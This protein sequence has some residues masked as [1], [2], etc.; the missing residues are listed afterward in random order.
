MTYTAAAANSTSITYSLVSSPA[1]AGNT[2]DASTGAV[3]YVAGFFGTATITASA[4]GCN[5]PKTA[6]HVATIDPLPSAAGTITGTSPV[7]ARATGVSYS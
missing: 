3:T 1:N 2:I 4:A 6:T 5:G 7:C